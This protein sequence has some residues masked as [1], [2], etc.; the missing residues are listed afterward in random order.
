VLLVSHC[1]LIIQFAHVVHSALLLAVIVLTCVRVNED[2]D[3]DSVGYCSRLMP[4]D[5]QLIENR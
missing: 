2:D 3:N 4:N 1:G 5:G